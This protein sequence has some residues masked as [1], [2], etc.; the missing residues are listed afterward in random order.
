[1]EDSQDD[2]VYEETTD[3][4]IPTKVVDPIMFVD[5]SEIKPVN[6]DMSSDVSNSLSE[7]EIVDNSIEAT[8]VAENEQ[9]PAHSI[10]KQTTLCSP[11]QN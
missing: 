3:D 4:A 5:D 9:Q 2:C 11:P 1:M 10:T 8:I 7:Q 6:V